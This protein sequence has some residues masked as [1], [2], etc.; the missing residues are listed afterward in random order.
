MSKLNLP[1]TSRITINKKHFQTLQV[2][3]QGIGLRNCADISEELFFTHDEF[4]ILLDQPH[5]CFEKDYF[6]PKSI[7]QRWHSDIRLSDL[8]E[9]TQRI[10][11]WRC[12]WVRELAVLIET[13]VAKRTDK[14]IAAV[15]VQLT[16]T[17]RAIH[18]RQQLGFRA[19]RAGASIKTFRPPG[20]TTLRKWFHRYEQGGGMEKALI[21]KNRLRAGPT[22]SSF[23]LEV[24][25]AIAQGLKSYQTTQRPTQM[26]IVWNTQ[27][28]IRGLNRI[29]AQEGLEPLSIPG[30]TSIKR[31]IRKLDKYQTA[32]K[33]FG[34]KYANDKFALFDGGL[35]LLYP[36]ERVEIDE[37]KID[38]ISILK[39]NGVNLKLSSAQIKALEKGRRWATVIIDCRTR[40][41]LGLVISEQPSAKDAM[42]A[43]HLV[44]KD[45]TE[46][47]KAYGCETSWKHRGG[48]GTLVA[49]N[50]SA[51]ISNQFSSA[52]CDLN[53]TIMYPPAGYPF[54]R[55]T[56]ERLFGTF[57]A[58]LMSYL[59]GRTFGNSHARGDYPAER[60]A[61]LT[62]QDLAAVLTNYIVDVY[63][64]QPHGGLKGETPN[65]CW[66]RLA[67]DY[68][69]SSPPDALTQT[70]VF[71]MQE[72]RKVTGKGVLFS[73]I[74]YSSLELNQLFLE[75]V[76]KEVDIRVDPFNL[77][78]ISVCIKGIWHPA[79]AIQD[80]FEGVT[81]DTWRET[82]SLLRKKYQDQAQLSIGVVE[83]ALN[84][85]SEVNEKAMVR[86]RIEPWET[87]DKMLKRAYD[88]LFLG[89]SIQKD[90]GASS[91]GHC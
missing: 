58:H 61:C 18:E 65:T 51:F 5:V 9:D 39:Q 72:S 87:T 47:A 74:D 32:C 71:G 14:S 75:G 84:R 33:R 90:D 35:D 69:I 25:A 3:N 1:L 34:V 22:R 83:R 13:G 54:L 66:A 41:I 12:L 31:R 30:E 73:G 23:T 4:L 11:H 2:N 89:M 21:P 6:A 68:G 82:M 49:D 42:R 19:D 40:C 27:T 8:S 44:G 64:N 26:K 85:I 86:A 15:L 52:V 57:A 48:F 88:E 62:D 53:S 81:L 20:A 43:L 78:W 60:L 79:L 38:L 45:K 59:N 16:A 50:G 7:E 77:G 91:S 10:V 46:I 76:Q 63:H 56:I 37:W 55:G 67:E 29:R 24:E 36:L 17:V 28:V 70:T 80:C